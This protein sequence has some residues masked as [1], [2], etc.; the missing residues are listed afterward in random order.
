[1]DVF[2]I[3]GLP[4]VVLLAAFAF[5]GY[6]VGGVVV[7]PDEAPAIP[8]RR[9]L[10]VRTALLLLAA[11][12][13]AVGAVVV[14]SNSPFANLTAVSYA[15]EP[16][17]LIFAMQAAVDVVLIALV[18]L[19]GWSMRRAW[20]MRTIG[21]YW[22]CSALPALI[23]ADPGSSGGSMAVPALIVEI[24]AFVAGAILLWLATLSPT[25]QA[26]AE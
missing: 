9:R 1:V 7:A 24:A 8:T 13:A 15:I 18:V 20:I 19:P 21:V 11:V 23:L 22:L 6:S 2:A 10:L 3:V 4:F 12:A 25:G 14:A 26:S 16:A 17:A 5:A